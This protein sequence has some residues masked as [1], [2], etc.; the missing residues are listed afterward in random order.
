ME[1]PVIEIERILDLL[2]TS[3][4]DDCIVLSEQVRIAEGY[5]AHIGYLLAEAESD[6]ESARLRNLPPKTKDLTETERNIKLDALTVKERENR[7]K[8]EILLK[9]IQQRTSLG[10]SLI[11][12]HLAEPR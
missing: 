9:A 11:K 2:S 1:T 10:Q 8:L 5:Y 12:A 4:S 7:D 6:Y 3:L